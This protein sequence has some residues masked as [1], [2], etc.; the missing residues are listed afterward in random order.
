M[1]W[2]S[3][4]RSEIRLWLGQERCAEISQEAW[5]Q[6]DLQACVEQ[7]LPPDLFLVCAWSLT[8][9]PHSSLGYIDSDPP[10]PIAQGTQL[11]PP[12]VWGLG[13]SM[14]RGADPACIFVYVCE[15]FSMCV[16]LHTHRGH[17]TLGGRCAGNTATGVAGSQSLCF[18]LSLFLLM[19]PTLG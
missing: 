10:S 12:P 17:F 19:Y 11:P 2:D 4:F 8:C 18:S 16:Y 15:C 9:Y 3:G 13:P 6:R 14:V 7:P 5:A 1:V